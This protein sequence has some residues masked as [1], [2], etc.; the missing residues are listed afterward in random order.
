MTEP[1]SGLVAS[2]K[3][4]CL[5]EGTTLQRRRLYFGKEAFFSKKLTLLVGGVASGRTTYIN[6][7]R[8]P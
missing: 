4:Q 8:N 2:G 3:W 7:Y 1:E 6:I 5:E